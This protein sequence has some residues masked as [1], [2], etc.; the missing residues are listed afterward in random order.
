MT[1]YIDKCHSQLITTVEYS[2]NFMNFVP[3]NGPKA[4]A[5]QNRCNMA[6]AGLAVG[7]S[8]FGCCL[9]HKV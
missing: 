4:I 3:K 5:K 9:S 8:A 1:V 6:N 2:C 7:I